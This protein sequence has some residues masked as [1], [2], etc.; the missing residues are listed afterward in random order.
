MRDSKILFACIIGLI[1]ISLTYINQS[2]FAQ[3]SA[4]KERFVLITTDSSKKII[5]TPDADC[6]FYTIFSLYK[7]LQSAEPVDSINFAYYYSYN[8]A[9]TIRLMKN[10]S[11]VSYSK[12]LRIIARREIRDIE[13]YQTGIDPSSY[14]VKIYVK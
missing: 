5:V 7:N 11:T 13:F 2:A 12:I 3:K 8:S 4:I 6:K 1:L 14:V 9:S 10:K